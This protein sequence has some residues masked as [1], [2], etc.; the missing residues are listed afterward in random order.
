[1]I[2]NLKRIGL[3]TD[4]VRPLYEQLGVLEFE[5]L[6]HDGVTSW[7][8]LEKPLYADLERSA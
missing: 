6:P 1:M 4:S 5:A 8:E 3:L 2:P 7:E